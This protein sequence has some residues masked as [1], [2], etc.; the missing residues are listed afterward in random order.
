MS[1]S[2]L[3]L[4]R[5]GQAS[6]GAADYDRLSELGEEQ[7]RRLGGWLRETGQRPDLVAVGPLL[8]HRQT[9][10][11]CLDAAG[12]EAPRATLDGLSELDHIDILAR[13]RPDLDGADAWSAELARADDPRRALQAIFVAAVARWMSGNFDAD[14]R[15][16]WPGFRGMVLAALEQL[17]EH[18][19]RTIWVYT[20]GGPIAVIVNALLQAPPQQTFTLSWPL[21]NTS[22]T[23]VTL[24]RHDSLISYNAWP[25]LERAGDEHLITYR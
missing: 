21:V 11:A 1:A 3:L 24:G 22:M 15:Q 19:A 7:S 9:V 2:K 6:F 13:H 8:R 20:S 12:I 5:H 23:R 16:D 10:D 25:H 17:R 18:A 14:Y 4:I